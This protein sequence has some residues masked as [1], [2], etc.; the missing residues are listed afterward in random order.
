MPELGFAG[1]P[2]CEK[3]AS[4]PPGL[5]AASCAFSPRSVKSWDPNAAK[6]VGRTSSLRLIPPS[7]PHSKPSF[8]STKLSRFA[9]SASQSVGKSTYSRLLMSTSQS[10]LASTQQSRPQHRRLHQQHDH[11][12][13][14]R[15]HAASHHQPRVGLRQA[16][17]R[18]Q[19]PHGGLRDAVVVAANVLVIMREDLLRRRGET[20]LELA[21]NEENVAL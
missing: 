4:P 11:H 7:L 13:V 6:S 17:Q 2:L 16:D 3:R 20:R 14:H 1:D 12:R 9:Y 5:L 18:L 21:L 8:D 19:Q 10:R 15:L